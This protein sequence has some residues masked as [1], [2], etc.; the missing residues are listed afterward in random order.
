MTRAVL[1]SPGDTA[2]RLRALVEAHA[3]RLSGVSRPGPTASGSREARAQLPDD[4]PDDLVP[5]VDKVAR[6]AY[7]VTDED[8]EQLEARG[9]SQDAIFELTISAILGASLGRLERGL[10]ALR[11]APTTNQE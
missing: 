6:Y 10:A 5:Y 4:L 11:D 9:Y 3:A 1:E 8:V 7:R 2:P